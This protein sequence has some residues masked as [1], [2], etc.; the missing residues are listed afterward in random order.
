MN[1]R[2]NDPIPKNPLTPS[3]FLVGLMVEKSHVIGIYRGNP[4]FLG[5]IWILR[6]REN[7]GKTL[8]MGVP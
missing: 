5:Y 6:D 4:G 8:G 1:S 3:R 7:G 2:E